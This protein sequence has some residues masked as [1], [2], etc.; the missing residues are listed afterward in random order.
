MAASWDTAGTK[1]IIDVGRASD[2]QQQLEVQ[3]QAGHEVELQNLRS[4]NNMASCLELA[5]KY[6]TE[7]HVGVGGVIRFAR[8]P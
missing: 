7:F 8:E 3:L 2:W 4:R 5:E 1:T 6:E